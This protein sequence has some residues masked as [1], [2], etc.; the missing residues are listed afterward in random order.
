MRISSLVPNVAPLMGF[1]LTSF[2]SYNRG[3]C[4]SLRAA[5][6]YTSQTPLLVVIRDRLRQYETTSIKKRR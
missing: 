1:T 2:G 3:I 6:R 4:S 5:N